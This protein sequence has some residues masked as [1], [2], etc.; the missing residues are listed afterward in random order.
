MQPTTSNKD[1]PLIFPYHVHNQTGFGNLFVNKRLYLHGHFKDEFHFLT[2]CKGSRQHI[3]KDT[4][5]GQYLT[6]CPLLQVAGSQSSFNLISL[7]PRGMQPLNKD[8]IDSHLLE[9]TSMLLLLLSMFGQPQDILLQEV[10][11]NLIFFIFQLHFRSS[12]VRK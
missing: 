8:M 9:T 5:K 2:M 3:N 11:R 12:K 10:L 6:T 7:E 1:S 4:Q